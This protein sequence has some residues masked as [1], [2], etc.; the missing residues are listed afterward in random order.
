MHGSRSRVEPVG[1]LLRSES[2]IIAG[3][4]TATLAHNSF[5]PWDDWVVDYNMVRD[6]IAST[7]PDIFHDFNDRTWT[8]DGFW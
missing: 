1:Q 6:A 3:I 5:A 8:P 4:S 2:A 7:Y